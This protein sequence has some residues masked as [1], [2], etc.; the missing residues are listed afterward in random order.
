MRFAS[1]TAS[2]HA[3]SA[4]PGH[5][6]RPLA[7]ETPTRRAPG[8]RS[9]RAG[10][11]LG[12]A[13]LR[14]ANLH[15]A[16]LGGANLRGA[17]LHGASLGGAD[18]SGANLSGA[19]LSGADLG[20]AVCRATIFADVDFSE[21]NGLDKIKH[22]GP[23]TIGIDTLFRSRGRIPEA[24]LRGCGVPE[25]LIAYLPSLIGAMSPIQFYSCFISYSSQDRDFADR[26]YADLQAKG[27]RCW[28]DHEH[29]KIGDE[30]RDVIEVNIRVHDK[31]LLVLSAHSVASEWVRNE[32]ETALEKERRQK[33]PVLFPIRLDEAVM[34]AEA[35]WA[36]LVR[37]SA[38]PPEIQGTRC[39][40]CARHL[41]RA[42]YHR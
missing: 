9:T 21:V 24:F 38:S 42:G 25:V 10:A 3:R 11:S 34:G 16:S 4:P 15:G 5:S 35:G 6:H 37:T 14:G 26:L 20:E 2:D 18:L 19:S 27:I 31:L 30:I 22:E 8:A 13:D 40:P 23:S 7:A 41:G 28:L 39:T 32:V 17:N 29:L 1:A 33:R 36:G 12:G